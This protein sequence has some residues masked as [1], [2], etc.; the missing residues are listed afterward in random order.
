MIDGPGDEARKDLSRQR[1]V[2]RE[3]QGDLLA[4]AVTGLFSRVSEDSD[5]RVVGEE[6][7]ATGTGSAEQSEDTPHEVEE[8]PASVETIPD[9]LWEQ[10]MAWAKARAGDGR[11]E[12]AEELYRE[13]VEDQ[14]TNVRA[15]NNLGVLLDEMGD[16]EQAVKYLRAAKAIEPRN[17][18]VLGNLG[19]A[20]A[21]LG[22]YAEAEGELRVAYRADPNNLQIRA[23]LGILLFRRGLYEQAAEELA[24]VCSAEPDHGHALFYK[25]E[26]LNRLGRVDEAIEALERVTELIPGNPKA[27]YT[28]GVLFDKKDLPDK[29]AI[30]YRKARK[31][32]DS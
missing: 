13:L 3:E 32:T 11:L 25:G 17:H 10:K 8:G 2:S 26:A 7:E 1:R 24:A 19:A 15:L 28:L 14:P 23:N 12:E 30:M 4:D 29:A 5:P 20:L 22:R 21:A 27:Y 16:P 18:E 9:S 31:L 6:L